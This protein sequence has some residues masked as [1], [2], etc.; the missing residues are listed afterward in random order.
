M[1]I[2]VNSFPQNPYFLTSYQTTK[3]L[4]LSK[5][6]EDI[7]NVTQNLKLFWEG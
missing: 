7:L 5:L 3:I 2:L 6:K 1:E 4:D